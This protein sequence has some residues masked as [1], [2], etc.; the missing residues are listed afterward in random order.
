MS[1][2]EKTTRYALC[3]FFLWIFLFYLMLFPPY[4]FTDI[5]PIEDMS[6]SFESELSKGMLTY[7]VYLK[8]CIYWHSWLVVLNTTEEE[9]EYV[10]V[11]SDSPLWICKFAKILNHK[12]VY[13][14]CQSCHALKQ[15]SRSKRRK[16]NPKEQECDHDSLELFTDSAYFEP[17]YLNQCFKEKKHTMSRCAMC[18]RMLTS[19]KNCV[20]IW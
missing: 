4:L 20:V 18:C 5:T 15:D 12:C 9:I 7:F 11:G 17:R 16:L 10:H 19:V 13:C 8:H 6:E 3:D 14:L 1:H 2:W